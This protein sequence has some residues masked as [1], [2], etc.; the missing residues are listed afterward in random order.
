MR[1]GK[2]HLA[3]IHAFAFA[4]FR[5]DSL[6]QHLGMHL[7]ILLGDSVACKG[8]WEGASNTTVIHAFAITWSPDCPAPLFYA[9]S[10]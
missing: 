6:G 1:G 2:Q 8:V 10:F 9:C 5:A 7:G 3:I 4:L